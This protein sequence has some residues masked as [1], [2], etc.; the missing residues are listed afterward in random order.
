MAAGGVSV[1]LVTNGVPEEAGAFAAL[2]KDGAGRL[3]GAAAPT[4]D[5][6]WKAEVE[7]MRLRFLHRRSPECEIYFVVNASAV[8]GPVTCTFRDTGRGEPERWNPVSGETGLSVQLTRAADGRGAVP[9]F[10]APHDAC[11]IVFSR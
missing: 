2:M 9:L 6:S 5:L 1:W 7:G 4:P 3:F 10:M 11:F 8:G